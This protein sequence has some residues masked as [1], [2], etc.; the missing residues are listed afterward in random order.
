MNNIKNY[1]W[2]IFAVIGLIYI[3]AC[4]HR[5]SPTVIVR[6]LATSFNSSAV[7]LGFIA[8]IYFY[9]YSASQPVVGFFTDRLGPRK[10]ITISTIL[11]SLGC[12]IFGTAPNIYG[13]ILGRAL[14]GMGASGVF[15]PAL[16]VFASWYRPN[17]FT[18]LTGAMIGISG[19]S[20]IAAALP[21]ACSVSLFG[22]RLTHVGIAFVSF[23]LAIL[24]WII[25]RDS[26][27]ERGFRA[28][29]IADGATLKRP[30]F[31]NLNINNRSKS[32]PLHILRRLDFWM[33]FGTMFFMGGVSFSFQG[34]WAIPY[35]MDVH[36]LDRIDAGELLTILPL[37][38]V[39][40]GPVTGILADRF[41]VRKQTILFCSIGLGVAAWTLLLIG[42]N[43]SYSI[44]IVA[45]FLSGLSAGGVL[46]VLFSIIKDIFPERI[47]GT[48]L[49]L[50]NPSAFVGAILYQPL[51]G[52]IFE[53]SGKLASGP[54]ADAAYQRLFLFFT[55]SYL[56]ALAA[57]WMISNIRKY[58][59][60]LERNLP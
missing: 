37:G 17:E 6:D 45:F 51:S 1:R 3:L 24:C 38:Y 43:F 57:V 20:Y 33:L 18:T 27:R 39:I 41:P 15:I 23:S 48:V 49:G 25:V 29:D 44:V 9:L 59:N 54:Y 16:K 19:I 36:G 7:M 14:I 2:G 4:F 34:L 50:V 12:L 47:M 26:P 11:A 30:S 31:V 5:M 28:I 22:W 53:R 52:I 8:S 42:G 35:L 56:L 40:S 60:P 46:P 32:G 10:V 21:L 55:L 13:A 58:R